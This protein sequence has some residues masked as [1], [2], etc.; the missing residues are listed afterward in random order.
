MKKNWKRILAAFLAISIVFGN[1]APTY[2]TEAEPVVEVVEAETEVAEDMENTEIKEEIVLDSE[3]EAAEEVLEFEEETELFENETENIE[4]SEPVESEEPVENTVVEK[5]TEEVTAAAVD[6]A[7]AYT[8]TVVSEEWGDCLYIRHWE[9]TNDG[10]IFDDAAILNAL[11]SWDRTFNQIMICY[12]DGY[13]NEI[14]ANIWNAVRELDGDQNSSNG[15][16]FDHGT[17]GSTNW[18]V[19]DMQTA[20]GSVSLDASLDVIGNDVLGKL[21]VEDTDQIPAD[22]VHIRFCASSWKD[23]GG[24]NKHST[25]D[26]II[27][28]FGTDLMQLEL[29]RDGK[30]IENRSD[31]YEYYAD[32]WDGGYN[33][34]AE[35][36]FDGVDRLENGTYEVTQKTYKGQVED[37]D[38]PAL[39]IRHE[40]FDDFGL[41]FTTETILD[42]LEAR[43]GERFQIV[44]IN[45][46]YRTGSIP[47]ELWNAAVALLDPVEN[48]EDFAHLRVNFYD[49]EGTD[50]NWNF[51][52][53]VAVDPEKVSEIDTGLTLTF[54][55]EDDA[56]ADK[57][58]GI[59]VKFDKTDYPVER[60]AYINFYTDND[61]YKVDE[62]ADWLNFINYFGTETCRVAVCAGTVQTDVSGEYRFNDDEPIYIELNGI[63][64]N[65]LPSEGAGSEYHLEK[66]VY[67]GE[68]GEWDDGTT[69]LRIDAN[70][71]AAYGI[72]F[73]ETV[74]A[75]ILADRN[76]AGEVY[77]RVELRYPTDITAI[78]NKVWKAAVAILSDSENRAVSISDTD[79][80]FEWTLD[81]N[82]PTAENMS[83]EGSQSFVFEWNVNEA[84]GFAEIS[85]DSPKYMA[86]YVNWNCWADSGNED[87]QAMHEALTETF[88]TEETQLIVADFNG[89]ETEDLGGYYHV[90][91]WDDGNSGISLNISDINRMED[92]V[93]YK[94]SVR[95]YTGEIFDVEN[96]QKCLFMNSWEAGKGEEGFAL[97]DVQEILSAH[98]G[99]KFQRIEFFVPD[100]ETDVIK[101]EFIEAAKPYLAENHSGNSF[102]IF[103]FHNPD[104]EY[105]FQVWVRNPGSEGAAVEQ[106]DVIVNW[107]V[108]VD[109]ENKVVNTNIDRMDFNADLVFAQY[110]G[111]KDS[112]LG[113]QF[114]ECFGGKEESYYLFKDEAYENVEFVYGLNW[115]EFYCELLNYDNFDDQDSYEFAFKMV[116]YTGTKYEDEDGNYVLTIDTSVLDVYDT[117]V[118]A[119]LEAN[120]GETFDRVEINY[121]NAPGTI[122]AA[123]WNGAAALLEEEGDLCINFA[124]E[125]YDVNWTFYK[126]AEEKGALDFSANLWIDDAHYA[127]VNLAKTDF[128]AEHTGVHYW[129]DSNYESWEGYGPYLTGGEKTV[130]KSLDGY[131]VAVNAYANIDAW[132]DPEH[133]YSNR[134]VHVNNVGALESGHDYILYDYIGNVDEYEDG[135]RALFINHGLA[136]K[137]D[138]LTEEE[139]NE[140]LNC[141]AGKKYREIGIEQAKGEENVIYASVVNKLYDLLDTYEDEEGNEHKGDMVFYFIDNK[142]FFGYILGDPNEEALANN[143]DKCVNAEIGTDGTYTVTASV[144]DKNAETP[145][146]YVGDAFSANVYEYAFVHLYRE[147]EEGQAFET[148]MEAGLNNGEDD[149]QLKESPSIEIG[150]GFLGDRVF[151][152][153]QYMDELESGKKYTLEH[154]K[155]IGRVDENEDENGNRYRSL[156]INHAEAGKEEALTEAELLAILEFHKGQKYNEI[157]IEQPKGEENVI[158]ASVANKLYE[159]LDTYEDEEGNEHKGDMVFYFFEE[160][161]FF[162]Y[163]LGDPNEN[164][165]ANNTDKC[166]NA[167]LGT[168][169]TYTVTASVK[170]KDADE[171]YEYVGDA[172]DANVYEYA[173]VHLYH[174]SEEGQAFKSFVTAGPGKDEQVLQL[175]E[176]PSIEIE[177]GFTDFSGYVRLRYMDELESGK[178]Y[179]LEYADYRGTVECE[180]DGRYKLN[181]FCFD[182]PKYGYEIRKQ[183][184]DG[185]FVYD[186]EVIV[187]AFSSALE[188][189]KDLPIYEINVLFPENT[190]EISAELWN[191]MVDVLKTEY[192]DYR[193]NIRVYGDLV[194]HEW[195]FWKP[196]RL[197][198]TNLSPVNISSGMSVENEIVNLNYAQTEYAAESVSVNYKSY[199]YDPQ[200][201]DL[202]KLFGALQGKDGHSIVNK[203]TGE[204]QTAMANHWFAEW[205]NGTEEVNLNIDRVNELTKG[206]TYEVLDYVGHIDEWNNEDGTVH[207]T[208][209]IHYGVAGKSEP[210]SHDELRA[211]L[212]H[213]ED[214]GLKYDEINL[215]QAETETN[216]V[217]ADISERASALMK[218]DEAGRKGCLT[219]SFWDEY[220]RFEWR[221][222]NP[223]A[224]PVVKD[225]GVDA[226]RH[227][228]TLTNEKKFK[229]GAY[230]A[231]GT[232]YEYI[233]EVMSADNVTFNIITQN[234]YEE[235][236]EIFEYPE[237][238]LVYDFVVNHMDQMVLKEDPSIVVYG[239]NGES[240][241]CVGIDGL[242]KLQLNNWYT[243][244]EGAYRGYIWGDTLELYAENLGKDTFTDADIQAAA[245]Y[246]KNV[247]YT[248]DF[249][250]ISQKNGSTNTIDKDIVNSLRGILNW[251][252]V[253]KDPDHELSL[254]FFFDTH[255][256][257]LELAFCRLVNPG[258]ATKDINATLTFTVNENQSVTVKAKKNT[259]N[260]KEV[261]MG[262]IAGENTDFAKSLV[263]S[264]G[265]AREEHNEE[266]LYDYLAVFKKGTEYVENVQGLYCKRYSGDEEMGMIYDF[267]IGS[268]QNLQGDVNYQFNAIN[269]MEAPFKVGMDVKLLEQ[270][271]MSDRVKDAA[272]TKHTFKCLT[273]DTASISTSGVITPINEGDVL[274]T[275]SYV[276]NGQTYLEVY[277]GY[278]VLELQDIIISATEKE[279]EVP[280]ND[281]ME[282]ELTLKADPYQHGI[283]RECI[284]WSIKAE[285]SETGEFDQDTDIVQALTW[286]EDDEEIL[287][288]DTDG[289]F[290]VYPTE[291]DIRIQITAGYEAW[292]FETEQPIWHYDS[293]IVTVRKP[294][295]APKF[296]DWNEEFRKS[297]YAITNFDTVL[298]DVEL[299]NE[300]WKWNEGDTKLAPFADM[301]KHSFKATYTE[302]ER[303]VEVYI[304]VP[305]LT[306]TGVEVIALEAV[307]IDED[308]IADDYMIIPVPQSL[309]DGQKVVLNG[310][311]QI[312]GLEENGI[313]KYVVVQALYSENG[314]LDATW[315]NSGGIA[316]D[317]LEGMDLADC[318]E[319]TA[320]AKKAG[321][322]KFTISL[323][324]KQQKNKVLFKTTASIKVTKKPVADIAFIESLSDFDPKEGYGT[325]K[326]RQIEGSDFAATV[327]SSDASVAR[328]K[329]VSTKKGV[330][331]EYENV[332]Y[333]VVETVYEYTELKPGFVDFTVKLKDEVNSSFV[334]SHEVFD[335]DPKIMETTFELNKA[336]VGDKTSV[337]IQFPEEYMAIADDE[338][339][340]G[341]DEKYSDTFEI[342]DMTV[343]T[344][345][346][347]E[348]T[349]ISQASIEL[350]AKDGAKATIHKNVPINITF[351]NDLRETAETFS[352]KINVKVINKAPAVTLKQTKS[353]N[354]FYNDERGYG[355]ISIDTKG[356]NDFTLD[357]LENEELSLGYTEDN[358]V[359][360]I[361]TT[362][363][364]VKGNKK[365]TFEYQITNDAGAVHTA[366]KVLTIKVEEKAPAIVMSQKSDTIYLVTGTWNS[367]L[368]LTDKATGKPIFVDYAALDQGK[369]KE[370]IPFAWVGV[371]SDEYYGLENVKASK[372]FFNIAVRGEELVFDMS[373]GNSAV[374]STEKY[375]LQI[376]EAGWKKPVNVTYSIKVN[377]AKPKLKLGTTKLTLNKNKDI[378]GYQTAVTTLGINGYAGECIWAENVR[379]TG[380]DAASN[381]VLNKAI[382]LEYRNGEGLVAKLHPEYGLD[383]LKGTYKFKIWVACGAYEAN[384]ILSVALTDKSA[385]GCL[386]LSKKGSI[387]V[388]AR[389]NSYLTYTVKAS[390]ISGTIED[391]WLEGED[392]IRFYAEMT[393]TANQFNIYARDGYDFSTKATYKVTPVIKLLNHDYE[394]YYVM[395]VEQAIKV[396]QG[397]PKVTIT[398]PDG[399]VLYTQH[400]N[401]LKLDISAV[402]K[403]EY[404]EIEDVELTNYTDVMDCHYENGELYL[405]VLKDSSYA[406]TFKQGK[407]YA[408]KFNVTYFDKAAN[409]KPV[410]VTYKVTIK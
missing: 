282:F 35:I 202:L 65:A 396:T 223:A 218:T 75:E 99:E 59:S 135:Y 354:A 161:G 7:A 375:T 90:D 275:V 162:G 119:V 113:K 347:D 306:I 191:Q 376:Q 208:L 153:L 281:R 217:Y 394:P 386:K 323:V 92:S 389:E 15:F 194:E 243:L 349:Y 331:Y 142:G 22:G 380:A 410:L 369:K 213:H 36:C 312:K 103:T 149:L 409:E 105:S 51:D 348:N 332:P 64:V 401:T 292:D 338:F 44:E 357:M 214:Y 34:N 121:N 308:G 43:A 167:E 209:N 342:L 379:I 107:A 341:I 151:V 397:K 313:P 178:E 256:Q 299:P 390:N 47:A 164:A 106:E 257:D 248:F 355:A 406:T 239:W 14:P 206:T 179:T 80:S 39:V 301:C 18:F 215:E 117:N 289:W 70:H 305:L 377:T 190:T 6:S 193:I 77:D 391:V 370:P 304:E 286:N 143:T 102:V 235:D 356:F 307:H 170:D 216:L 233:S 358:K 40:H 31:R 11:Q 207:R 280:A 336:F 37:W 329:L 231:D 88:G 45:Y 100:T 171:S 247:G 220:G 352:A 26:G 67:T 339:D 316:S 4:E 23:D 66:A 367:V 264:I 408:L 328:V 226:R 212:K 134:N 79:N 378:A 180:S 1:A 166:V 253:E 407:S 372:N 321:V 296:E 246:Y 13:S 392:S 255:N 266:G 177:N 62:T 57:V 315:S 302:G 86:E 115:D 109:T 259:Y 258:M 118:I 340:I 50:Q 154:K 183:N 129:I 374:N 335:Y 16:L 145:Y 144:R 19:D 20:N 5:V 82:K 2:A 87:L 126:P 272:S 271:W 116:P 111:S 158:Y 387:D 110:H 91:Y 333:T 140:I 274:F 350:A 141:H 303:S 288:G 297:F 388:L 278:A 150:N 263:T 24:A 363:G 182:L 9:V 267:T 72:E 189:R 310:S 405:S 260:A 127:R 55:K 279:F 230:A 169:G 344:A 104:E 114:I 319:F 74:V 27:S 201:I 244:E 399:N 318:Y 294:L 400:G 359:Y 285:N 298:N 324:D 132:D 122:Q 125:A 327:T 41:E 204:I 293:C 199:L 322:K 157:S 58:T 366:S 139:L 112:G 383:N 71:F 48:E 229:I 224:K 181:L 96:G 241:A 234:Y 97:S 210:F 30:A 8:G 326:V 403:N 29:S 381:L 84:E 56:D 101:A 184:D 137:E 277:Q 46:P 73:D 21:T 124:G 188:E 187:N 382:S 160:N 195:Y 94:V 25:Y 249:I 320:D 198:E 211:I 152:R 130:L 68:T 261:R 133:D 262:V 136:G 54:A 317:K 93:S 146:Q 176:A 238:Q 334:I 123:V 53:P 373:D 168:D 364:T 402:L 269:C 365:I 287:G 155:Y 128:N 300:N 250:K 385:A 353:V 61:R 314:R 60:G 69:I 283:A 81:F 83:D 360:E 232:P 221:L 10:G 38:G 252:A 330:T 291:E 200:Y 52:S 120:S 76:S 343:D 28:I 351:R 186:K 192:E 362:E 196:E 147:N 148:F 384:T 203:A 398:A 108:S 251:E 63:D 219:W 165:L 290:A 225:F 325:I 346:D 172:F 163:I 404:V 371:E 393:G 240:D 159:L 156:C 205:D 33:Y 227:I 85:F 395:A 174:E 345:E 17:E 265:D 49:E 175:K 185:T 276:N 295:E 254:A 98:E 12:S 268:A 78:S 270:A 173:F 222:D 32:E 242:Q 138:S 95:N 284:E 228:N 3:E 89:A 236:G 311:T 42:V 197:D 237:G 337:T 273:E 361:Y 131:N 245:E 368:R 309:S